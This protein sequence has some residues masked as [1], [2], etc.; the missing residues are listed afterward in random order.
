M[1][2]V[3]ALAVCAILFGGYA[4]YLRPGAGAVVLGYTLRAGLP[5]TILWFAPAY[6][7]LRRNQRVT[8]TRLLSI[9]VLPGAVAMFWQVNLG[10]A[11]VVGGS[12]L[13]LFTHLA[14]QRWLGDA[15]DDPHDE[16]E[17]RRRPTLFK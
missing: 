4:A 13:A 16:E 1:L 14:A 2:A 9:G 11:Y 12:L 5:F 7:L 8:W 3:A 15:T 17:R 10:A 6:T